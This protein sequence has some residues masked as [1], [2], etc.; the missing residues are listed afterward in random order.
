MKIFRFFLF[1]T[2]IF[3]VIKVFLKKPFENELPLLLFPEKKTWLRC[4]FDQQAFTFT[5]DDRPLCLQT[6]FNFSAL[7]PLPV[8]QASELLSIFHNMVVQ[9][10]R[11]LGLKNWQL[12]TENFSTNQKLVWPCR[13]IKPITAQL[14]F[15]VERPSRESC[16]FTTL[17]D[18]NLPG[19]STFY[20]ISDKSGWTNFVYPPKAWPVIKA[21]VQQGNIPLGVSKIRQ[22]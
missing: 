8:S 11:T 18:G 15:S 5:C 13:R 6:A 21:F 1:F 14:R 12:N 16:V 7:T 22:D 17:W 9:D 4:V 20:S 3:C 10:A 19:E 2:L